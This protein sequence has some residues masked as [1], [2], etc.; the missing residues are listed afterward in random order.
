MPG[1]LSNKVFCGVCGAGFGAVGGHY[2]SCI[3]RRRKG[4]CGNPI[5]IRRDRLDQLVL[6]ALGSRLMEPELVRSFTAQWNQ[7]QASQETARSALSRELA[8]IERKLS[9]LYEAIADGL[10]TP[11]LTRQLEE[12]EARQAS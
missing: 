10:R 7:I 4:T 5:S 8:E 9:G 2:L 6:D 12:L 11:G 3:A 1:I